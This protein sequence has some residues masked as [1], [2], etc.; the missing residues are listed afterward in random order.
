MKQNF[1]ISVY[2]EAHFKV[3]HKYNGVNRDNYRNEINREFNN[4]PYREVLISDLTYI[5]VNHKSAYIC[6]ITD[7]FNREII[8]YSVGFNKTPYLV[9]EAFRKINNLS[10]VKYFH[11][12][13][14]T[15]FKNNENDKLLSEYGI[16]RSLSNPGTPFDNACAET[17][18]S[19][20]KIE[21]VRDRCFSSLEEAKLE[22]F[23]CIH[24]YNV[25]RIHQSLGY[26]SP[27]DYKINLLGVAK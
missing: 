22:L 27:I 16:I 9:L 6:L 8:G 3:C 2:Q 1:L 5:N 15:E 23:Q 12:D 26:L 14:G 17:L 20:L 21:F 7:L 18:Y 13:R 10:E 11:S 24:W 4:R 25:T 19:S